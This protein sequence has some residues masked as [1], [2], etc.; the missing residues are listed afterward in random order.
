MEVLEFG[1]GTGSTAIIHAPYVKQIRAIDFSAKMIA[2]ARKKA[3]AEKITNISFEQLSIDDLSV[4]DQSFDMIL[5]L[6][7]LHLLEDKEAVSLCASTGR[8]SRFSPL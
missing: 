4:D 6:S 2:I 8:L 7:I 3:D 5:G 1:C